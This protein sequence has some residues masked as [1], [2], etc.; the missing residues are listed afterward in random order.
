M[1][2]LGYPTLV[3]CG[4]TT[5]VYGDGSGVEIEYCDL[6]GAAE[7]LL[8]VVRRSEYIISQLDGDGWCVIREDILK[9]LRA[10]IAKASGQEVRA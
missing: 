3:D 8:T 6:H 1:S 7:D 9:A 10:S 5:R 4:C 2:E